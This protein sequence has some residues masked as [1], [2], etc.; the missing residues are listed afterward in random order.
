MSVL[1]LE[2][3]IRELEK[4][5]EELE[6]IVNIVLNRLED[7]EISSI[8]AKPKIDWLKK[9]TEIVFVPSKL[10]GGNI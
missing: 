2:R 8:E 3:R 4:R 9:Y 7:L 6:K 5:V 10:E 1:E